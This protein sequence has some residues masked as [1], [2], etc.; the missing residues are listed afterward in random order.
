MG[1]PTTNKDIYDLI[2]TRLTALRLEFKG[3]LKDIQ[4]D[5]SALKTKQEVSATK[6]GTLMTAISIVTSAFMA[7]LFNKGGRLF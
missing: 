6:L 4:A 3:D 2:D 7:A 1:N 5:V